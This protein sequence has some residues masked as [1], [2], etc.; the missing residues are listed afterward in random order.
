VAAAGA[1]TCML[2]RAV[3]TWSTLSAFLA[4]E[5]VATLASFTNEE[6]S[7]RRD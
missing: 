5:N 4:Y 6:R 7:E 1:V 2:T 3:A